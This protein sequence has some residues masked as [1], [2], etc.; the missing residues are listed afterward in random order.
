MASLLSLARR[1]RVGGEL[2]VGRGVAWWPVRVLVSDLRDWPLVSAEV[3]AQVGSGPV[4]G[5]L[6]LGHLKGAA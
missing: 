3:D 5:L 4:D 6:P 2:G 1:R